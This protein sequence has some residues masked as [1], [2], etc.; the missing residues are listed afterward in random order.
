MSLRLIATLLF[1]SVI[2][3][4]TGAPA[5]TCEGLFKPQIVDASRRLHAVNGK[6]PNLSASQWINRLQQT[7]RQTGQLIYLGK[8]RY[9]SRGAF[10]ASNE[11][12]WHRTPFDGKPTDLLI[13]FGTNSAWE[14][15]IN[16]RAKTMIVADW[17]PEP[18]LAHAY[19]LAPLIRIS[20]SPR[21]LILHLAGRRP[22][23]T[24]LTNI[25]ALLHRYSQS[26]LMSREQ[27]HTFLEYLATRNE[28]RDEELEF[29]SAF[30]Y[31]RMS[32]TSFMQSPSRQPSWIGRPVYQGPFAGL[33][34]PGFADISLFMALRY[35]EVPSKMISHSVLHNPENYAK[36][37]RVFLENRVHYA[38]AEIADR[39]FYQA[40]HARYPS[41]ASWTVSATNI[42]DMPYA[43]HSFQSMQRY[44]A[45]LIE[46]A[47]ISTGKLLTVF[48]TTGF[49]PPHGFYRYDIMSPFNIPKFDEDDSQAAQEGPRSSGF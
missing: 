31:S 9:D 24:A 1:F 18:V 23:E 16:K 19:V 12:D 22:S 7:S 28:I 41:A 40:V 27:I 46:D 2:A 37:R 4:S 15:A 17:S 30:F 11:F 10:I 3:T 32:A 38:M 48:R 45:N 8:H 5:Q 39:G 13:G 42:F 36:L 43:G 47:G 14:I 34:D 25:P 29:L 20:E 33:R 21:E 44:L 35:Q 26:Y 49:A 6:T